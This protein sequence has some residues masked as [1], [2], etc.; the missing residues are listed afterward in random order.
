MSGKKG[1]K[2]L[3]AYYH[4]LNSASKKVLEKN[5]FKFKGAQKSNTIFYDYLTDLVL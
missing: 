1:L 4:E 3:Q 5:K 2:K